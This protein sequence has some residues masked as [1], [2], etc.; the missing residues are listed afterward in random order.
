MDRMIALLRK[1]AGAS[2]QVKR[3][4]DGAVVSRGEVAVNAAPE[5]VYRLLDPSRSGNR[6][7]RR[8]DRIAAVDATN[9]LYR[10]FDCRMPDEPFLIQVNEARPFASISTTT[11]GDGGAPIGA[12]ARSM[13]RYEIAP[14]PQGCV[15]TLV[16]RS[17]FLDGLSARDVARH[18][19]MIGKGVEM[20]LV[21]LKSEA[22]D[23][24]IA[25]AASRA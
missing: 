8:G 5:E 21:R 25:R 11:L 22:E 9:G 18:A 4:A 10:L 3:D 19:S 6:W 23:A 20:D 24:D 2:A 16:E 15:V 17:I 12:I 13:S 14:A 7:A 1:A